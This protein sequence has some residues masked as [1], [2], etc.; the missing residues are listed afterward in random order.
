[1]STIAP[2]LVASSP[3]LPMASMSSFGGGL[4]RSFSADLTRVMNR[5]VASPSVQAGTGG[6]LVP[7][8]RTSGLPRGRHRERNYLLLAALFCLGDP[9]VAEAVDRLAGGE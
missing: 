4:A 9:Q 5:I 2:A 6:N 8:H 3:S 1:M 7:T